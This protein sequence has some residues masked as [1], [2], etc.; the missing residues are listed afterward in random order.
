MENGIGAQS[1]VWRRVAPTLAPWPGADA[2][3]KALEG[4]AKADGVILASEAAQRPE[5]APEAPRSLAAPSKEAH[6]LA[7]VAD[8]PQKLEATRSLA[9]VADAARSLSPAIEPDAG[10]LPG[11][12][13]DP[14]CMGTEA[15]ADTAVLAGFMEDERAEARQLQALARQSPVWARQTLLTLAARAVA[16]ARKLA[17][18]HYLITG[19]TYLPAVCA[20]RIYVGKWRPALR[21]RYHG[22][23]CAGMNYGRAADGT[24]DPC[25]ADLFREL[26]ADAF[27]GAAA[28]MRLLERALA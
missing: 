11:A 27:E 20:E 12:E 22:A 23:A 25:L 4:G 7:P 14:C 5:K 26:S 2:V 28:V 19:E 15:A 3:G 1:R 16:R 13:P 18:A 8:A 10:S 21:E 6:S 9:P 24:P 17:A